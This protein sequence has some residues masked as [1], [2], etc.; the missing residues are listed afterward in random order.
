MLHDWKSDLPQ[1]QE[2]QNANSWAMF[3]RLK[4]GKEN[5]AKL[6]NAKRSWGWLTVLTS[7]FDQFTVFKKC[8]SS[9]ESGLAESL[10]ENEKEHRLLA[11]Y[12]GNFIAKKFNI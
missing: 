1:I 9:L 4:V 2:D 12:V 6:A 8:S 3:S 11:E 7:V 5:L 10:K